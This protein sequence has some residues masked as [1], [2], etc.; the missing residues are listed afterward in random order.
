[1][2]KSAFSFNGRIR[3]LEYGL[4]QIIVTVYYFIIALIFGGII[5]AT[6]GSRADAQALTFV[7][8]FIM[9]PAMIFIWAQGAKRC[10]DLGNSGW[11][12]LI[13]FYGLWMLFQDGYR[14]RNQY[15][16]DPK[17]GIYQNYP[18]QLQQ[19]NQ[20]GNNMSGT[21]GNNMQS[22][23]I[24]YSGG[25]NSTGGNNNWGTNNHVNNP[26]PTN[27]TPAY[28]TKGKE[29]DGSNPYAKN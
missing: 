6:G 18:Q 4:S 27:P 23:N 12:Q 29:F 19:N 2:F 15:G 16:E 10:H 21:Y 5:G 8:W 25:H 24:N 11:Y 9:I 26:T 7:M 22:G 13:P 3:R 20:Y 1:M 28:P 17:L 14:G